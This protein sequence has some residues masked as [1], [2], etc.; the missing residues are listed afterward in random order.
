M[1]DLIERLRSEAEISDRPGQFDRLNAL[2]DEFAAAL[3]A[4]QMGLRYAVRVWVLSDE[5]RWSE[6]EI[7]EAVEHIIDD[8]KKEARNGC[9]LPKETK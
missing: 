2:A 4:A 1:N 7:D 6:A 9:P 3:E 5:I 8:A